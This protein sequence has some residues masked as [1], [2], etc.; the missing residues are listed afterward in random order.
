MQKA[1]RKSTLTSLQPIPIDTD[2]VTKL[3]MT[4]GFKEVPVCQGY[5]SPFLRVLEVLLQCEDI[6]KC[7]QNPLQSD[8]GKFRCLADGFMWQS[9]PIL[10]KHPNALVFIA[11]GDDLQPGDGLSSK[12][13]SLNL[14]SFTWTLGNVYPWLRST[15]KCINALAFINKSQMD[16]GNEPALKDFI[17]GINKLST[18]GVVFNIKGTPTKFFGCLLFVCGDTPASANFAGM[19]ESASATSPCRLCLVSAD[20]LFDHF[21]EVKSLLRNAEL[22]EKHLEAISSG[23]VMDVEEASDSSSLPSDPSVRYGVNARS[24]FLQINHFDVTKCFPLD[25]MHIFAE[26]GV[27]EVSV[28][29]LIKDAIDKKTI[30]LP[31]INEFLEHVELGPLKSDRPNVIKS[32][33][34][35]QTLRQTASQMFLLGHLVPFILKDHCE[36]AKLKNFITLLMIIS[37]CLSLDPD[38]DDVVTLRTLIADFLREFQKLYGYM[39]I[40]FHFLVH[41]PTQILMFACLTQQW[42]MRFEGFH[43]ILKRLF[44]ILHNSIN[45]PLSLMSR[46]LDRFLTEVESCPPGKFLYSGHTGRRGPA[47]KLECL[48]W[49]TQIKSAM[50]QLDD[51]SELTPVENLGYHGFVFSKN[52]IIPINSDTAC[53]PKY[54]LLFKTFLC[55]ETPILLCYDL[56]TLHFDVGL[57]AYAVNCVL[58]KSLVTALCLR[59][60]DGV[61]PLLMI[62]HKGVSYIPLMNIAKVPTTELVNWNVEVKD[63]T[64]TIYCSSFNRHFKLTGTILFSG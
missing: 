62:E 39:T 36:P 50:P 30:T 4:T 53:S 28:R 12:S 49:K 43:A 33:H 22:H 34:L 23:N 14:R 5:A 6:L 61:R 19:K 32:E 31:A 59:E 20:N 11:Y 9:H 26:N 48:E 44:K 18:E 27:L 64:W 41:L 47:V 7:V 16:Q 35:N 58:R 8:D 54:G 17:E 42:C 55:Q 57:N 46:V 1:F 3:S 56:Q 38:E 2:H 21:T 29:L 40:K 10:M 60:L 45:V 24:C 15:L 63:I 13:S 52:S 25:I 51:Q 37:V